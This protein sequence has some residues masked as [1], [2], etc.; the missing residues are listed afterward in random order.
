MTPANV[1]ETAPRYGGADTGGACK[2]S[3][4]S[5]QHHQQLGDRKNEALQKAPKPPE[6]G[7]ARHRRPVKE[8]VRMTDLQQFTSAQI[9]YQNRT[10][11]IEPYEKNIDNCRSRRSAAE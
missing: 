5:T 6:S 7:T 11:R 4:R 2:G 9:T 3:G 10:K 8:G 1:I